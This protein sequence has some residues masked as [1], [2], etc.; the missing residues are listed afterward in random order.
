MNQGQ[1]IYNRDTFTVT[2]LDISIFVVFILAVISAGLLGISP[3]VCVHRQRG[4]DLQ[5]KVA[6][7]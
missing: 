5:T 3:A 6:G 4:K 1:T 2:T 7:R